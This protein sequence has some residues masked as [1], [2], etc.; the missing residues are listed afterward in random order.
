[1]LGNRIGVL[2]QPVARSFDL[3]DDGMMKKAV[4]QRGCDN[5]VNKK[6]RPI[7]QVRGWR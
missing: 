2:A 3:H 5:R 6:P 7:L 4:E 1:M